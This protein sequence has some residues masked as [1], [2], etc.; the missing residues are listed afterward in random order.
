MIS[1]K[2][3]FLSAREGKR[4]GRCNILLAVLSLL[5]VLLI[6]YG[7]S[8]SGEWHF[9]DFH[10]ILDNRNVHLQGLSWQEIRKTFF[11]T[12]NESE[13]RHVTRPLSY[14]SFG[15]NYFFGGT[16]VFGYHVVNFLLHFAT[17]VFLFLVILR[18]LRLPLL[19]DCYGEKSFGIALLAT[20]FWATSPL[21]VHAVTIIVQR[22]TCLAG[23]FYIMA[24]YFYVRART[25][26][27]RLGSWSFSLL[28]VLSAL[29][30]LGSKEN[31]AV[32]PISI[33]LY[34]VLLIQGATRE[35]FL[36]LL[37]Y[38]WIPLVLLLLSVS[39]LSDW[40]VGIFQA[41]EARPFSMAERLL[42]APRILIFYITLLLYPI[43]SRLMLLHDIEFSRSLL[44]PWTTLPALLGVVL[45]CLAAAVMARRKPLLSYCMLFFFFNHLIEGTVIPLELIFEHRNYIPSMLFFVPVA[46]LITRSLEYFSL[47]RGLQYFM[48]GGVA[49]L[50]V[51]QGHTTFARNDV[52]RSD[53]HL[54][55]DNVRKA[56]GLSRPHVN[57]ARHYYEA[58][59]YE[60]AYV[61]LKTAEEL[62]RDTNLRQIGIASYNLG[63]Y[64]LEQA[65]DIDC[66]EQKFLKALEKFPGYSPAI[67]GLTKVLLIKG[68]AEGAFRLL[69]EYL[70]QYQNDADLNNC[71]GLVLLK[72]GN[73][74]G[75]LR[76]AAWSVSLNRTSPQPWEISGEASKEMGQLERAVQCWEEA[77]RLNPT[78]PRAHLALVELYDRLN[79]GPALTRMTVR[80]LALKGAEPLD[81]WLHGFVGNSSVSAYEVDPEMLGR[82]I[83][84]EIEKELEK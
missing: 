38:A 65:K 43:P 27:G 2:K 30:A 25:E 79:D 13:N 20:F 49:L 66:A 26:D 48:A 18:T 9:D 15:L 35:T 37:K 33:L 32:L 51:L 44:D 12:S 70:P 19:R 29:A 80:C 55:L 4:E 84:R 69:Q 73:P 21:H 81:K 8:F 62:N 64:Y 77:L 76:T 71:Y 83:R 1:G 17:T 6:I 68:D 50:L 74:Q 72:R 3:G 5:T 23:L 78:N 11:G 42:T 61:E 45:F 16:D 46:V 24:L 14:L 63:V 34:D 52:V 7:N 53:V 67:V 39:I 31:A 75:A 60:Q 28:C 47:R 58:G 54:W 56:P 36:R 59:M 22:M 40:L 10:N 57:L 41:Y 82:V